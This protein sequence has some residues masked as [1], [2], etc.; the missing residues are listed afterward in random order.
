MMKMMTAMTS[1]G[2]KEVIKIERYLGTGWVDR[3][4]L[5]RITKE[6]TCSYPGCST[7]LSQYNTTKYCNLHYKRVNW[8]RLQQEAEN[9]FSNQTKKYKKQYISKAKKRRR[10]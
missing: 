8:V 4:K 2:K 6:R 7:L 10:N 5:K 9:W 1:P 3:V